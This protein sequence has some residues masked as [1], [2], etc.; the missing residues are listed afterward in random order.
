[1]DVYPSLTYRDVRAA[2]AWLE[3]AFGLEPVTFDEDDGEEIRFA[4]VRHGR[5]M[6][7]VQPELPQELHGEHAGRGWVYVVVDD[8]DAH[9]ERARAA[10][11]EVLGEPHDAMDGRQR[12]FSARDLED[13]L[14]SFGTSRPETASSAAAARFSVV[15]LRDIEPS[16]D[17][18][19]MEGRFARKHLD[20]RELGV[21]YFRYG[22]GFRAATGH[23]HREQEEAYVVVGG[24]GRIKLDDEVVE[25]RRWDVV[26]VAP[27]VVRAFEGGPHGLELVAIGGSK[28]EGGDGVRVESFWPA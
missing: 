1:M 7:M 9:F 19:D 4:A 13:N 14:W 24:S 20:S 5:G 2:L 12:G 6:V 17:T 15:N 3:A 21:S 22:P 25:L 27:E 10:G 11:A 28:P 18:D 26:R 8:P 23:H 16:V